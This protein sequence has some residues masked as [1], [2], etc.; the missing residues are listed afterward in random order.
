MI[1]CQIVF[2]LVVSVYLVSYMQQVLE[3]KLESIDDLSADVIVTQL[4]TALEQAQTLSLYCAN[5]YEI[6]NLLQ[7][8]DLQ[9][10]GVKRQALTAGDTIS[11][12]LRTSPID[13]YIN[14]L[15][16]FNESGI[17]VQAIC[18]CHAAARDY[19]NI[20]A[21]ERYQQW[22]DGQWQAF[23]QVEH[24]LARGDPDCFVLWAS[25]YPPYSG[26]PIG[27]VYMEVDTRLV[28]DVLAAYDQAGPYLLTTD[29]GGD[30][31]STA[32]ASFLDSYTQRE[33]Q[34]EFLCDG[35]LYALR[36]YSLN[37]TRNLT[38]I[39]CINQ[40]ALQAS[41]KNMRR[42]ISAVIAMIL[43]VFIVVLLLLTHYITTPIHRILDKIKRLSGNDFSVDPELEQPKNELGEVGAQLNIL[44][45]AVDQLLKD[46]I[47]LHDECAEI[48]M[49][50]LQSQV[51]PH[52]LYN[53]L[54]SVHY[55]AVMQK[56]IGI[57]K[58]VRSLVNLLENV[59]KGVSDHIPLSGELA[60]LEDYVQIQSIRYIGT[61]DYICSVPPE[62][63][64]YKILKFT[65]QPLVEN[66]IFHGVV[67]KGSYGTIT[68]DAWEDGDDLVITVT[69]DGVG[70]TQAEA[71]ALLQTEG[72]VDKG[73]LSSIGM[74]NVNRRLKLTYGSNAGLSVESVPGAY[75]KVFVRIPKEL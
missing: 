13:K 53:T 74:S 19:E 60:L 58:M 40:T 50:L 75:T 30:L 10:P 28:T 52:F 62:L 20:L 12:Y 61:F 18:N 54:N 23:G 68:L 4:D 17:L 29:P 49:A 31:L 44:G 55:M 5:S 15:F 9:A 47:A 38:L 57:E 51:N 8:D 21:S 71:D 72:R 16:F 1:L 27:T 7:Y 64:D 33:N 70:M 3:E 45:L 32:G 59:S 48:E 34:E 11:A 37:N 6:S 73:S 69:D 65:L 66:A 56:N 43:A 24:A 46:T 63:M 2:V 39:S 22:K 36:R 67:P 14:K 41:Q 35:T 26:R 42:T 25:V